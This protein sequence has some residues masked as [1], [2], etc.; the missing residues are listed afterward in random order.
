MEAGGVTA[1]QISASAS[2]SIS[3]V[4][5]STCRRMTR[6]RSKGDRQWSVV[7][8]ADRL[9]FGSQNS[10]GTEREWM[11][12]VPQDVK[13]YLNNEVSHHPLKA[14]RRLSSQL[15]EELLNIYAC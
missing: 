7:S 1:C 2:A 13:D 11:K 14:Y 3:D 6:E 10:Y 8:E 5:D 9:C 4:R 15:V 12:D